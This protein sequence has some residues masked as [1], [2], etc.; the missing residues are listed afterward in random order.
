[1]E[2]N[3]K[4]QLEQYDD[5]IVYSIYYIRQRVQLTIRTAWPAATA[6]ATVTE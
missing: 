5:T 1:M 4:L 3:E 2:I 6:G